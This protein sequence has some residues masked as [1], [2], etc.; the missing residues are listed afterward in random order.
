MNKGVP[1][2]QAA[3]WTGN[4]VPVLQAVYARCIVGRRDLCLR[5]VEDEQALP[6]VV[7]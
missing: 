3:E 6:K 1:H 4:S 5:Q 7:A 2:E